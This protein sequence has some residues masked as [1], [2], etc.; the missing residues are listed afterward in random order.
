MKHTYKECHVQAIDDWHPNFPDGTVEV[1]YR[2]EDTRVTVIGNDDDMMELDSSG[3]SEKM[4]DAF[5]D[6][7]ISH[8]RCTKLGFIY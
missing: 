7:P 2:R 3:W 4:F 1:S 8:E 6:E 5:C